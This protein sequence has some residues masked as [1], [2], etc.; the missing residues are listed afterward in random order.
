MSKR[1]GYLPYNLGTETVRRRQVGP[2]V[3]CE[4]EVCEVCVA[5]MYII[6]VRAFGNT[7]LDALVGREF[8]TARRTAGGLGNEAAIST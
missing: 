5:K 6:S 7:F 8:G 1:S 2:N 3:K 4:R